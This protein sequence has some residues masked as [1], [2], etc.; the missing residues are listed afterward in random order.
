MA[1]IRP[2]DLDR[3]QAQL[4]SSGIQQTNNP[5]Y[6]VIS[7]LIKAIIAA[8]AAVQGNINTINNVI[9]NIVTNVTNVSSGNKA[10][11]LFDTVEE[12]NDTFMMIQQSSAATAVS[13]Y[14]APLTDGDPIEMDLI[15]NNGE[16]IMVFIPT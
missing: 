12:H 6:Q 8:L 15:S 13:G 1:D 16:T 7:Q 11:Y 2:P 5:L 4:L 9:N 10:P 3:L 14:W